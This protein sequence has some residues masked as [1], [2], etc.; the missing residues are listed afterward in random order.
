[1]EDIIR[2]VMTFLLNAAW[3]VPLF[4]LVAVGCDGL[5]RNAPAR[6]RHHVWT[7]AL[8]LSLALPLW[9]VR[10]IIAAHSSPSVVLGR[11]I[12]REAVNLS[13]VEYQATDAG[14]MPLPSIDV[15]P[16][17]LYVMVMGY[18]AFLL[19]RTTRLWLGWHHTKAFR[20]G[21]LARAPGP[22]MESVGDRCRRVFGLSG[23]PILCSSE[24]GGPLTVG[25]FAP[26]VVLPVRAFAV[27]SS[28]LL[29][30]ILG[31]EMAHVRRND[32]VRNLATEVLYTPIALHPVARLIKRG[33]DATRE[34][35]CDELVT[36][37]LVPP[38]T[39][40]RSLVNV[41]ASMRSTGDASGY[42]LG[43]LEAGNLEQRIRRLS[44]PRPRLRARVAQAALAAAATAMVVAGTTASGFSVSASQVL[45]VADAERQL[46][47]TWRARWEDVLVPKFTA[48][49]DSS[50]IWLQFRIEEGRVVGTAW[51]DAIDLID[52]P[53]TNVKIL[54]VFP[55][56]TT[57][58]LQDITTA[59]NSV[60]FKAVHHGEV[61]DYQLEILKGQRAVLKLRDPRAFDGGQQFREWLT[62]T[63]Q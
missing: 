7:L 14:A 40:A 35:A 37:A 2:M 17:L 36:E 50:P 26:V 41:A 58:P 16:L 25:A 54:Q 30:S 46:V 29:G 44:Q 34:L 12:G 15:P 13:A 33:I 11:D 19:A 62:L 48:S 39:Y 53:G 43:I 6:Y 20:K 5:L 23:V 18:V 22:L 51:H 3:Q 63:K 49:T 52:Q 8:G 42:S 56:N 24:V 38:S 1:M 32:F 9:S 28:D 31:H 21:A 4:A 27:T 59:G 10:T 55:K 60:S 45:T 47:G 61:L 57:A